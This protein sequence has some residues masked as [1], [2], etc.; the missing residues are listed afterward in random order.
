MAYSNLEPF[1]EVR[2]D[3]RAGVIAATTANFSGNTKKALKPTDLIP[4]FVQAKK[5]TS[6]IDQKREQLR[7]IAMFKNLAGKK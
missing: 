5:P 1:G 7:Q 6:M 2:A 3:Y 4:I